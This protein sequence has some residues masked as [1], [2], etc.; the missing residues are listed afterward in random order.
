VVAGPCIGRHIEGDI[1]SSN[2]HGPRLLYRILL[3]KEVPGHPTRNS[4][5][6]S[7]EP[8]GVLELSLSRLRDEKKLLMA[9]IETPFRVRRVAY[10]EDAYSEIDRLRGESNGYRNVSNFLQVVL[11]VGSLAATGVSGVLGEFPTLRWATLGLTIIVGLSSGFT[12]YFK[13]K[14]RSFYLQQTA[15][16]IENEW[17]AVEIGVGRYKRSIAWRYRHSL[18]PQ[19][20]RTVQRKSRVCRP[21]PSA[22]T[23]RY[24]QPQ[25]QHPAA[26]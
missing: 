1:H 13:Y 9:S 20:W 22:G 17:E 15:D 24:W 19:S 18:R 7:F 5:G 10:K 8:Q 4:D 25:P 2:T 14:E 23:A 6:R 3:S 16:A 26:C 21:Q 11:I 12:G